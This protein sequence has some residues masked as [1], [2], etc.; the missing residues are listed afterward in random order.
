FMAYVAGLR[1]AATG[2]RSAAWR[3]RAEICRSAQQRFL[4]EHL[5]WWAPAFAHLLARQGR[6]GF[7]AAAAEFL[8]ALIPAERALLIVPMPSIGDVKPTPIDRPEECEG[9]VLP[10]LMT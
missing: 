6:D 4:A 10:T 2:K 1:A 9:C 7:Y 3:E 5:A 8:A